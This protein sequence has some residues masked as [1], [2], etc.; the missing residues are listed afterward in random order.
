M[1][2]LDLHHHVAEAFRLRGILAQARP[3][4]LPQRGGGHGFRLE[5]LEQALERSPQFRLGQGSD[6]GE[7]LRRDLILQARELVEDLGGKHIQARRKEL[8][9]LDHHA[10]HADGHAAEVGG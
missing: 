2:P 4:N 9:H 10:A 8:A 6:G 5:H 7:V 3:V 1:R